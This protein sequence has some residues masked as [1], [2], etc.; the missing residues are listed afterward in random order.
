MPDLK[1]K[2]SAAY[3][4]APGAPH[5]VVVD[6]DGTVALMNGRSPYDMSRVHLDTPNHAVISAVRAMHAAGHLV[7]YCSGRTD[8]GRA[9]TQAWLDRHVEQELFGPQA[10]TASPQT[11][12]LV[13][14]RE[15]FDAAVRNALDSWHRPDRLTSN[16]LTRSRIAVNRE[17]DPVT[18]LRETLNDAVGTLA[19][20]PRT[21]QQ[22]RAAVT[23]FFHGVPTQEVAAQRLG[24]PLSTYRRHLSRALREICDQ[25]WSREL[26]GW[27]TD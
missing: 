25:L 18:S 22:H 15:E 4:P 11:D 16:P 6:I 13:L 17:G 1:P 19:R 9:D 24:L 12:L 2:P 23:T 7:V 26:Y 14:S 27:A 20:D 10:Q 3:A 5:A 8:D 21:E